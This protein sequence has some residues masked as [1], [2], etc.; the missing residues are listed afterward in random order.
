MNLPGRNSVCPYVGRLEAFRDAEVSSE[1]RRRIEVHLNECPACRQRLQELQD[2]AQV[3]KAYQTPSGGWSSDAQFWKSLAPQLHP[4]ALSAQPVRA[5]QPS[6]FLAPV[7]V[8][9][10]SL[11]LR[12][13]ATSVLIVYALY[14][15][16]VLPAS[17]SAALASG[18]RLSVGPLVWQTGQVLYNSLASPTP[19]LAAPGHLWLFVFE[20][21]ASALLLLLSG[22]H[23]SWLMRWLRGQSG[24][25]NAART[26]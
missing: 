16:Q 5:M 7:T 9:V 14:Q 11:A 21:T 19:F 3:L 2:L 1:E 12:G 13:L 24:L 17:L 15:W 22:L 20:A 8:V 25:R 4:R 18:A 10:S 26:E 6:A 23:I